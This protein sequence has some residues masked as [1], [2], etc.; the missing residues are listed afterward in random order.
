MPITGRRRKKKGEEKKTPS[1]TSA[2][3]Q[4]TRH[5]Q[6]HED[7]MRTHTH[8]HTGRSTEENYDDLPEE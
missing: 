8:T 4:D 3:N 6:T 7:I 5:K 2:S 1:A